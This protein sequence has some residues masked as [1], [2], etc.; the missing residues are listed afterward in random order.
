MSIPHQNKLYTHIPRMTHF[1]LYLRSTFKI[2]INYICKLEVGCQKTEDILF[3]SSKHDFSRPWNVILKKEGQDHNHGFRNR[4]AC[5]V[6]QEAAP[7]CMTEIKHR[8]KLHI[9]LLFVFVFFFKESHFRGFISCFKGVY[10][11][12]F[13]CV[14]LL[15][16]SKWL[17]ELTSRSRG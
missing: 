16:D 5:T 11:H 3:L 12:Y 9:S 17:S 14:T 13:S 15:K 7:F 2:S 6:L 10:V 1:T 4:T 8:N